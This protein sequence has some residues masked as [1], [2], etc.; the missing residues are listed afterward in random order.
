MRKRWGNQLIKEEG[1]KK[2]KQLILKMIPTMKE[3]LENIEG[4]LPKGHTNPKEKE[5][6]ACSQKSIV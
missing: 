4:I 2:G 1:E 3:E 5:S 6:H